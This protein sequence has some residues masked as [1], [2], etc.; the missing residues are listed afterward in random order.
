MYPIYVSNYRTLR[1]GWEQLL[2]SINRNINEVENQIL[3]RDS[4]GITQVRNVHG[5]T[6][7][8]SYRSS[9]LVVTDLFVDF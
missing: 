1:V 5:F 4:K 8:C 6:R 2:T 7:P 3:T 9:C